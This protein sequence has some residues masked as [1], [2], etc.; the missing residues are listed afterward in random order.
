[1]LLLHRGGYFGSWFMES[2]LKFE[3][4]GGPHHPGGWC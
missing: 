4:L 3:P 1:V 2:M